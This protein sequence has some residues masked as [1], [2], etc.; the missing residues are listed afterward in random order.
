LIFGTISLVSKEMQNLA[1]L[2]KQN[3]AVE[4]N[5]DPDYRYYGRSTVGYGIRSGTC[6]EVEAIHGTCE[7]RGIEREDEDEIGIWVL[8]DLSGVGVGVD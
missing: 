8:I 2:L 4:R 3:I 6:P 5:Q 1:R 7:E